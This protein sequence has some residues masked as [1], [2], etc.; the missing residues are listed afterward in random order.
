M[1]TPQNNTGTGTC[2]AVTNMGAFEVA[3][4]TSDAGAAALRF[5]LTIINAQLINRIRFYAGCAPPVAPGGGQA[6]CS[7]W[8]PLPA[9]YTRVRGSNGTFD[10]IVW[11]APLPAGC[12]CADAHNSIFIRSGTKCRA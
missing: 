6:A 1:A 12:D 8:R 11:S 9:N 10:S 7:Q 5:N 4:A 3:C 2:E